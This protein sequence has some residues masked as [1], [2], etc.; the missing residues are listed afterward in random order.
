MKFVAKGRQSRRFPIQ[1]GIEE[2]HCSILYNPCVAGLLLG[3]VGVWS[4]LQ[5]G[6]RIVASTVENEQILMGDGQRFVRKGRLY[7][8]EFL[9]AGTALP[10]LVP[11]M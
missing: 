9:V 3:A 4:V 6:K 10:S 2:Q 7:R 5:A 1:V 11:V 8:I